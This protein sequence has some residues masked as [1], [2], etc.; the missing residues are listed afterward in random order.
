MRG[1]IRRSELS[2]PPTGQAL[3][4]ITTCKEGE[5]LRVCFAHIG[6]PLC[7]ETQRFIPFDLFEFTRAPFPHAQER[8]R[9]S[10]RRSVLLDARC[11]FAADYAF[12]DRMIAIAFDIFD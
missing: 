4:L 12:I 5:F 6:E 9:E 2:G 11:A 1:I 7:S 3:A 8:L 10:R